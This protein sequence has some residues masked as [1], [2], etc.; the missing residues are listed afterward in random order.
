[1]K[2][3][4]YQA[5]NNRAL[6]QRYLNEIVD[7]AGG[8]PEFVNSYRYISNKEMRKILA[9]RGK[10]IEPKGIVPVSTI[11][12]EN[13]P[14]NSSIIYLPEE[15]FSNIYTVLYSQGYPSSDFEL[16]NNES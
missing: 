14:G 7:N 6:R 8:K 13:K 11:L 15:N 9:E 4:H 10:K 12:L 5:V 16:R 1:M 3:S 2:I